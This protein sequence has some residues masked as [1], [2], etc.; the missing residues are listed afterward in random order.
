VGQAYSSNSF[1]ELFE[2]E[3]KCWCH[4]LA[5]VEGT[6]EVNVL[7]K[8]IQEFAPVLKEAIE[9]HYLF[10]LINITKRLIQASRCRVSEKE[11]AFYILSQLP[12][13][14][15]LHQSQVKVLKQAVGKLEQTYMGAHARLERKWS[16][17]P[18]KDEMTSNH[19]ANSSAAQIE[20]MD[21]SSLF[22]PPAK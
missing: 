21:L 5:Q 13:P 3:L 20:E 4:G 6:V 10:D 14:S 11:I 18:C 7:R 17:N 12:L 1:G 19:P 22:F 2:L 9:N 16:A 15:E 8:V